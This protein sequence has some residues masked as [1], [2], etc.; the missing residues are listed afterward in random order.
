MKSGKI[1]R[2]TVCSQN[3]TN[4]IV[5][6]QRNV[7]NFAISFNSFRKKY[8]EV[9]ITR[10]QTPYIPTVHF[11]M[12]HL[13]SKLENTRSARWPELRRVYRYQC[14]HTDHHERQSDEHG[15]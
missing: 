13:Y 6:A 4:Q 1:H 12:L 5:S 7:P 10:S 2:L 11:I 3:L 15:A 14:G 9:G 8:T